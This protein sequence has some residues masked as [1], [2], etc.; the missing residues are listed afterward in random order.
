METQPKD[1]PLSTTTAK[2]LSIY[3]LSFFLPPFGLWPAIK[4]LKQEDRKSK[5][6]G[7]IAI[8]LTVLALTVSIF[9]TLGSINIVSKVLNSNSNL[10]F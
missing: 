10:Y 3:F 4:Y 6:I 8:F 5:A 7:L 2:Q 1:K 9:F